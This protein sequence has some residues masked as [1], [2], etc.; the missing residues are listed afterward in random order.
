MRKSSM[1][2]MRSIRE[3]RS[4]HKIAP[5]PETLVRGAARRRRTGRPSIL[6]KPEPHASTL[7]AARGSS[8]TKGRG[9]ARRLT[10]SGGG[11]PGFQSPRLVQ[12]AYGRRA[13]PAQIMERGACVRR[14]GWWCGSEG[15]DGRTPLVSRFLLE[16]PAPWAQLDGGRV[17]ADLRGSGGRERGG[18]GGNTSPG[19]PAHTTG[20]GR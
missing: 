1:R 8:Q 12:A 20:D 10:A 2:R 6:L 19:R 5:D 14:R 16:D 15:A 18:P 3:P 17:R 4:R 7:L 13:R 9:M 11:R